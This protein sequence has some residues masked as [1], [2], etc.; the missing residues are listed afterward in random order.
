M[1]KRCIHWQEAERWVF[2]AQLS[3]VQLLSCW[4]RDQTQLGWVG[5]PHLVKQIQKPSSTDLP[6]RVNF[7][8]Q[9][10]YFCPGW[11]P[12]KQARPCQEPAL[13]SFLPVV[14]LSCGPLIA[15]KNVSSM[16]SMTVKHEIRSMQ[17]LVTLWLNSG[18]GAGLANL[19]AVPK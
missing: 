5:S 13:S 11:Y 14:W 17:C 16:P 8:S 19:K 4:H 12:G 1:A 9:P 6:R 15:A 10:G 7:T 2:G 18:G 3:S